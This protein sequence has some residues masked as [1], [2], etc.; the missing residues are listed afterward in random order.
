MERRKS[1][2]FTPEFRAEAV[3]LAREGSKSLPQ[4]AK[5]LDLTE[6]ALRNWVREA[7]GGEGKEL[8]GALSTAEP[9]SKRP[10]APV[11]TSSAPLSPG[12]MRWSRAP[13]IPSPSGP[14]T[15]PASTLSSGSSTSTS[16]SGP[17]PTVTVPCTAPGP[18]PQGPAPG[19]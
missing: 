1:R 2:S 11:S 14:R 18:R 9:T 16:V 5:D 3:R 13:S 4:V 17:A 19:R 6:S 8:A 10:S 12:P 15:R 7:D